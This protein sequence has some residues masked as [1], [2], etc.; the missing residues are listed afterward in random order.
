MKKRSDNSKLR[1]KPAETGALPTSVIPFPAAP[2][3]LLI[4]NVDAKKTK[5]FDDQHFN[6]QAMINA[7]PIHRFPECKARR[8]GCRAEFTGNKQPV[9][10]GLRTQVRQWLMRLARTALFSII[11]HPPTQV[12]VVPITL[13]IADGHEALPGIRQHRKLKDRKNLLL[14]CHR[15]LHDLRSRPFPDRN[16]N[17]ENFAYSA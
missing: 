1:T 10:P 5:N 16:R 13:A 12:P 14:K 6:R 2:L 15:S 9:P 3:R 8:D 17:V 11:P 7:E 4:K